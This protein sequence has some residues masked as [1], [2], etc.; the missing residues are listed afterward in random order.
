MHENVSDTYALTVGAA[1]SA[2]SDR[3]GAERSRPLG[4]H[5]LPRRADEGTLAWTRD[6]DVFCV[7][8]GTTGLTPLACATRRV[9]PARVLEATPCAARWRS[10]PVRI[11]TGMGKPSATDDTDPLA[12]RE[13]RRHRQRPPL[14]AH[15]G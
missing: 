1:S 9:T 14:P 11:H 8:A 13:D 4:Q 5:H 3:G 6:E 15:P 2:A 10:A 12:Q 7:A